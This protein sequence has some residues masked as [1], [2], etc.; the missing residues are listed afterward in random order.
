VRIWRG[1]LPPDILAAWRHRNVTTKHP[2]FA[3]LIGY[4]PFSAGRGGVEPGFGR[5]GAL[6][7]T[8]PA[9]VALPRLDYGPI[10]RSVEPRTARVLFHARGADGREVDW[11]AGIDLAEDPALERPIAAGD[12]HVR[13]DTDHV[14][15]IERAGL[16]PQTR[17]YYAPTIDGRRALEPAD[18][19]PASFLTAPDLGGR[20]A[21]FTVAFFADQH[22]FDRAEPTPLNAYRAALDARPLFWAQLGDVVAGN[23]DGK[24]WEHKRDRATIQRLFERN[25]GPGL[26]QSRFLREVP[27]NIATISDHEIEN[28]ASLNWHTFPFGAAA[29]AES[30][31]LLDY[32]G[33]YNLSLERWWNY[34]GRGA[35]FD[36][37]LGRVA[38]ADRG[39]SVMAE[40]AV[41]IVSRAGDQVVCVAAGD[42][43]RFGRGSF[44]YLAAPA[45][46]TWYSRVS[47]VQAGE[48]CGPDLAAVRLADPPS[49]PGADRIAVGARYRRPGLYRTLRPYPFVEF[50]VLDTTSYRG[51]SYHRRDRY[52]R[53]ANA[54]VDH[55]RYPWN[56]K[57]GRFYMFGDRLHG[58]NRTTDGVRSWLGPTQKRAF[59][60]ALASSSASVIVVAAGYPLFSVKF[61]FSE[62]FWPGREAGF[63]YATENAEIVRALEKLDTLVLWVHGD[64]HTPALVRL[65]PNIY[66]MQAGS[67]F[68]QRDGSGHRSATLVSGMRS[69]LDTLGGGLLIAGHQPDL[70]P[71]DATEDVFFD[72]LD[73]FEGYLRMY[74]HPGRE[75]LRSSENGPLRRGSTDREV[76]IESTAD[77]AA[78]RAA[79]E[80]VGKVV[81]L[82]S[83]ESIAHSV[84]AA[85]R[86]ENGRA[87]FTLA[88]PV[89]RADPDELRVIVDAI[90]WVEVKWFDA[91][92][93]EWRDFSFVIRKDL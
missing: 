29:T 50:F 72:S 90:P 19:Q 48:P 81:R 43:G 31:T 18:G 40:A 3:D 26:P 32:V 70:L 60:D 44:V 47:A 49:A 92:G 1:A 55:S 22:T 86:F 15:L 24:T 87:V 27:L 91:R 69:R 83:G 93:R 25:F 56:A 59:L 30:A 13:G 21:D 78:G 61:E 63:D 12:V 36:D 4:W 45:G 20:N 74:F 14:A 66:Q 11:A 9:W 62:R 16:D 79:A 52:A 65:R 85:Y 64:G 73:Q 82:R 35:P 67:T 51:D 88:D 53:E 38:A 76:V 58:A 23:L 89:V 41:P 34:L 5:V 33:Q 42:A 28:G 2:R 75:I 17:Y 68:L 46:D 39:E 57:D 7:S 84:I 80:V 77:P 10:L 54:D 37:R 8:A 6:R 71:G